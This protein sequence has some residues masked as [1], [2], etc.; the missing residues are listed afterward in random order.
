[1]LLGG[2]GGGSCE[3]IQGE[4]DGGVVEV[5]DEDERYVLSVKILE[6]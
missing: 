3:Q 2:A 1:M 5:A 4:N 6:D